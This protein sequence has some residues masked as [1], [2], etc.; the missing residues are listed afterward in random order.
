MSK[1]K[2]AL[3]ICGYLLLTGILGAYF[4]F[5]TILVHQKSQDRC[6]QVLIIVRDSVQNPLIRAG[7]VASFL[8]RSSIVLPG[9]D[10]SSIDMYRLEKEV[11]SFASVRQCNAVKT[12][13]GTL[14]LEIQQHAPL[15]RLETHVGSFFVSGENFIFPVVNPHRSAVLIVRGN[16]PFSYSPSYRGQMDTA[17]TWLA[18]MSRMTGFMA[19][20]PFW[21][22]KAETIV[23][24][25]YQDI[26][27]VPQEKDLELK[28]GDL[29]RF[30]YKLDKLQEF[31]R[32]LVPL[33]G[34]EKYSVVDARFGDQLVC[35][36]RKNEKNI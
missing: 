16:V 11:E 3:Q 35:T 1:W 12:I 17:D 22:K 13:D 26:S 20:H 10:F 6:Q 31:Y 30:Q 32:V 19:E 14:K 8:E 5:A 7:E 9:R 28:I 36:H 25:N 29:S 34:K 18:A 4:Y 24:D 21:S 33:G 15:F 27:I 23:I 2:K